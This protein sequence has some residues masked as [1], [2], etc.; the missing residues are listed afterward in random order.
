MVTRISSIIRPTYFFRGSDCKAHGFR[1]ASI[2]KDRAKSTFLGWLEI[3]SHLTCG[4]L[5]PQQ[6]SLSLTL[7]M[8]SRTK[9][10][11]HENMLTKSD[12]DWPRMLMQILFFVGRPLM[13]DCSA[14]TRSPAKLNKQCLTLTSEQLKGG[15]SVR[16]G[17]LSHPLSCQPVPTDRP[18]VVL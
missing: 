8:R 10:C 14:T 18:S 12:S 3:F 4:H 9:S 13:T 7:M 6:S 5:L 17:P 11:H 1:K 15:L 16:D 2:I